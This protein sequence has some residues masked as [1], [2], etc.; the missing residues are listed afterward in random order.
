MEINE[1]EKLPIASVSYSIFEDSPDILIDISFGD[2][3]DDCASAMCTILEMLARDSSVITT[4][5]MIRNGLQDA[6]QHDL[7]LKMLARIGASIVQRSKEI[8][9]EKENND[10]KPCILP[11][12][13]L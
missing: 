5:E 8:E 2:Y 3:D 13:M 9:K 10:S 11:S 12:D 6:G 7:F 1:E 4:V